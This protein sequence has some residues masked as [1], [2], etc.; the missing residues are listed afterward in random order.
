MTPVSARLAAA[1]PSL[2][3]VVLSVSQ[4]RESHFTASSGTPKMHHPLKVCAPSACR[5]HMH[6]EIIKLVR[7]LV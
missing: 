3:L 5:S 6:A 1:H 4:A 7:R 2:T